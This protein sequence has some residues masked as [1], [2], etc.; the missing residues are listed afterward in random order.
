MST[1]AL[2]QDWVTCIIVREID[3][4][5]E[6]A[7]PVNSDTLE[8]FGASLGETY[9]KWSH[10]GGQYVAVP[11]DTVEDFAETFRSGGWI[12]CAL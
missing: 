10:F 3:V 12:V 4:P 9:A 1:P 7:S 5:I 8:P 11:A 2:Q 6:K